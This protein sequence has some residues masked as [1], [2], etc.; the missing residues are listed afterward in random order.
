MTLTKIILSIFLLTIYLTA[1]GQTG[2]IKGQVY[3]RREQ[4]GLAFANVLLIDKIDPKMGT[5]TDDNGNY[6]IG[7]IP[8][9]IYNLKVSYIGYGDTTLIEIK[10][11]ADTILTINLE[12]P[13]PCKYDGHRKNKTCPKCNKSDK[14]IPI[15]YGLLISTN[16]E[17][18]L[19]D[20]GK[21][22]KS[23]GCNISY[24]DP[25]WFCKRDKIEF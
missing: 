2:M 1:Y 5:T 3:D 10:I 12:L 24:C 17:D 13:P 6:K 4:K 25:H 16:E 9:G 11:M 20:E 15:V 19:K 7:K 23:G 21:T 22:F 18:P 8:I 14:V